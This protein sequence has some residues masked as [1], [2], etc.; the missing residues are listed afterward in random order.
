MLPALDLAGQFEAWSRLETAKRRLLHGLLAAGLPIP[1]RPVD[2]Q[3]LAFRFPEEL[4][5]APEPVLTGHDHG[6]ITVSIAEADDATREARRAAMH[7][8]YRTLL[9]HFRHEIGHFYWDQPTRRTSGAWRLFRALFGDE[10][11]DY[12]QALERHYREGAPADWPQRHISAYAT[13]APGGLGRD[14]GALDGHLGLARHRQ[15][16][17]RA[18]AGRSGRRPGGRARH[19][20]GRA[21]RHARLPPGAGR[22]SSSRCRPQQHVASSTRATPGPSWSPIRCWTGSPSCTVGIAQAA[23]KLARLQAD[24]M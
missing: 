12:G 23:P 10:R 19:R 13:M 18:A 11:A 16:L 14:L 3:G 2:P 6:L 20:A 15:P 7:E 1:R 22:R 21:A 4:P 9:G 17:G 24:A 5:D 8:P